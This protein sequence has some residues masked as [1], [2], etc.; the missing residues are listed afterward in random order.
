MAIRRFRPR[1]GLARPLFAA[2]A[3]LSALSLAALPFSALPASAQIT[4]ATAANVQYAMEELKA[5]FG[6]ASGAEAKVVYGAS[7]NL[8]AQIRNGAPF[9]VFVSA[10]M[11]F[12]DSLA[13][14][15]YAAAK[16]RP[17][18]YGTLILWTAKGA[19]PA[20]GLAALGR[21]SAGRIA[22]ADPER[23]PYGRAAFMALKH[24]G[25]FDAVKDRL[26]YGESIGQV[27]Q[28]VL[29]GTVEF[30]I[31]A[32]SAVLAPGMRDKGKWAEVDRSLYDPIAQGAVL[33][34][35]GAE[36]HPDLAARFLGYLYSPPARAILAK[37]GYLTPNP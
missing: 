12:P 18:A 4:I 15:G 6:K 20:Q 28:Y 11:E 32:K 19:V 17:Y 26:V 22:L 3:A 1:A 5:D 35:H 34:R 10:D 25:A 36:N 9:D 13:A 33:C 24:A 31:T 8:T 29:L 2:L 21:Q 30:G 23:A 7:G 27:N 37:Y 14:W 16:P